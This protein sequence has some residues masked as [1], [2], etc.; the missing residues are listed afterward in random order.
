MNCFALILDSQLFLVDKR[1][2]QKINEKITNTINDISD[3]HQ[4]ANSVDKKLTNIDFK[5]GIVIGR[6]YNS[7]YYQSRRILKRD[8][9]ETEFLEF[10]E[11]LSNR[12]N[13]ILE[14]L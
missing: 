9:T 6:L 10:L 12:R 3:I 2:E 1:L 14:K 7:F 13:E 4:I 5:F 8:P 11:I